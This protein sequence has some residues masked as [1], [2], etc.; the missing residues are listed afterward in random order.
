MGKDK[1]MIFRVFE[2]R[3][4]GE[5]MR[6]K[7][8]EQSKKR[9]HS[10]FDLYL[11]W[12]L[13]A[14]EILMSFT[15]LGYVHIPPISVTFAYIPILIAA[16]LLGTWQSAAIGAVFGLAS[17]YKSTSYYIFPADMLFSPFMSGNPIGSFIL[18]VGTRTL[19]GFLIGFL[20]WAAKKTKH[21]NLFV[22]LAAFAS[23]MAQALLV[24]SAMQLFFSN[25]PFEYFGNCYLVM[26]NVIS[27]VL[28]AV[29]AVGVR[30]LHRNEKM[31]NIRTAIDSAR[32]IPANNSRTKRITV[33]VF[34]VFIVFMTFA[35]AVYFLERMSHML[36]THTVAVAPE[37]LY[38]ISHMQ[39]EF[40]VAML[41]L[42]MIS[43]ITL[44]AGYQHSAYRNY[45][46]EMDALTGIMGR[47]IFLNLCERAQKHFD[48][49]KCAHGW[50]LI[51]DVDCFKAI[52]DTLG[53]AVGDTV[54]KKVALLLEK[55]FRDCAVCGR[56]GGDEFAVMIDK[57]ELSA[58]E[59]EKR[60]SSF[61]AEAA[62]I[63]ENAQRVTCS[64]GACRFSFPADMPKLM[65][66]TDALLYKTKENGRDGYTFGEYDPTKDEMR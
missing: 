36:R 61:A 11:F 10:S 39:I 16:L 63:L 25:H 47:R 2:K 53:H 58:H 6:V 57:A 48:T 56:M 33:A 3:K 21:P 38:N 64:I 17:M 46:G 66:Q 55:N 50:F 54:L 65:E 44:I 9:G 23:P 24:M 15:F 59:L 35:G 8:T 1:I 29:L 20:F 22:G 18:A 12:I 31:Q 27:S 34:T 19:F 4:R 62:G 32:Y 13:A 43:V 45:R 30:Q 42:N 5:D 14:F 49:Q 60:L 7:F 26:S 28:C 52:N 37:I 41:S 51:L 40:T